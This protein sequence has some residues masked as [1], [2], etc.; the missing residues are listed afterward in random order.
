MKIKY[1]K[2][3]TKK[4]EKLDK[5]IQEKTISRIDDFQK[6]PFSVILNNHALTGDYK[7]Y[8]S[9]NITGDFRAIFREYP[10]GTY[11]FVEFIDIGTH[12]QLY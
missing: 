7:G 12:S 3:F 4:F 10:D 6:T 9:I 8:R 1:N 2:K 11:E 5:I